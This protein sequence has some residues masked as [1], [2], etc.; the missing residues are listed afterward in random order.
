MNGPTPTTK[1]HE[2]NDGMVRD[3]RKKVI[4]MLN[5]CGIWPKLVCVAPRGS[6]ICNGVR[7][8]VINNNQMGLDDF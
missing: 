4:I 7:V 8:W 3:E 2:C 1:C 5:V 6:E